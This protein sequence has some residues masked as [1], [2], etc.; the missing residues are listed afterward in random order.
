MQRFIA[1]LFLL[2]IL[3]PASPA[4]GTQPIRI[5]AIFAQSGP[6]AHSAA[7]SVDITRLA[8]NEI[9]Q[10]GGVLGRPLDL[11]I[12]DNL[13]TPI[14]AK[15]AAERAVKLKVSAI[16]GCAWSSQSLAVARVA[17]AN[18]IPMLSN[19]STAAGLTKLGDFI[20]RVCFT[21]DLQGRVMAEFARRDLN[22]KT[23]VIATDIASD[24]SLGLSH[25]FYK[26]F[27]QLGGKVL[28]VI[29]YKIKNAHFGR[30]AARVASLNPQV[31][32]L[33]G[34][35]EA[36]AL[37]HKIAQTGTRAIPLGGDGWPRTA[38]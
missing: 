35:D 33:A 21:D 7:A 22:A 3:I 20:F 38:S 18:R 25:T 12:I 24:Y 14:G 1:C 5:A 4:L 13:S 10:H 36:G 17:Q 28:G 34:H 19:V 15:V 8:V 9:N 6:A 37:A 2:L 27:T 16:L 31:V 30:L 11:I 32:F 26:R 29:K 23:A